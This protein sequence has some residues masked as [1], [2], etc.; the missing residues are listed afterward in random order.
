MSIKDTLYVDLSRYTE[1]P[2]SKI[3]SLLRYWFEKAQWH[4]PSV[5]IMDNMDELMKAEQEV[6]FY[7]FMREDIFSQ[8]FE[9]YGFVPLETYH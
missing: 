9:A 8:A 1:S 2:I 3:K 7:S 6:G 4:R 5:I